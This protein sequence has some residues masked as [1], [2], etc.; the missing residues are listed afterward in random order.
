MN[1][2]DM[3]SEPLSALAAH[4]LSLLPQGLPK[5]TSDNVC[6]IMNRVQK[7]DAEIFHHCVRVGRGSRLLA[8]ALGLSE[9][10]QRTAECSG[11]F[12]DIGKIDIPR[13][14]LDKPS[15]L[16]P[17]EMERMKDHPMISVEMLKPL[18]TEEFF[19]GCLPGVQ[20]H[21]EWYDGRG[22]PEGLKGD[23]IPLMARL[24]LVIDAYDAITASRIYR[25]GRPPEAAYLE[26]DEWAGAQFDPYLV[27]VF[28]KHH[29]LWLETGEKF[30]VPGTRQRL[31]SAS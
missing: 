27:K 15:R 24:V 5:N 28:L 6:S 17:Q 4:I 23:A 10:E 11:L 30:T 19:V 22:Y 16:N 8:Q 29:P 14:I 13:E 25:P 2:S 3:G 31:N 9:R 20:Y 12:H 7:K 26:L 1:R 21:H 18:L